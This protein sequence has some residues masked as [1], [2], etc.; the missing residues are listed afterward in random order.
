MPTNWMP[1]EMRANDAATD[2]IEARREREQVT[3]TVS[4]ESLVKILTGLEVA[5]RSCEEHND[6]ERA[7]E[8]RRYRKIVL[9][10]YVPTE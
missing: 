6:P 1:V 8:F 7:K 9:D 2:R 10:N 3:I 5:A 4:K